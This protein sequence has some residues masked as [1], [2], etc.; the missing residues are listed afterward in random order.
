MP[1]AHIEFASR[2]PS[3]DN[4]TPLAQL[5]NDVGLT[6][7]HVALGVT[8]VKLSLSAQYRIRNA[9]ALTTG[10]CAYPDDI[11]L[12][13]SYAVRIV[14]VA[15]EFANEPCLHSTILAHEMRHVA[16][17]DKLIPRETAM[18]DVGLPARIGNGAGLWGADAAAADSRIDQLVTTAGAALMKTLADVRRREQVRQVDTPNRQPRITAA[19]GGRLNQLLAVTR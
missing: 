3:Y 10:V 6:V 15:R 19:C 2:S 11:V 14:H 7:G 16:L 9:P 18:F 17:D 4:A 5:S 13:L 1:A 12:R 8:E